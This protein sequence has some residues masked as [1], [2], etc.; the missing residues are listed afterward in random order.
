MK[1]MLRIAMFGQKNLSREGG[2]ELVV[3]ELC[4]RLADKGYQITCYNR[5]SNKGNNIDFSES[6]NLP[7]VRQ[8]YVPTI[9]KK[10]LAA[11]T[12]SAFAALYSAL[13]RYDVVHIHAEGPAFFARLPKLF[14]KRGIV[15]IH[16]DA[17]IISRKN[18]GQMAA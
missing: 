15:T 8:V 10:G 11:V 3:K 14:G 13:G 18:M 16:G 5:S 9:E 1:E 17:Q 7:N 6:D 12:A 4:S 2:V